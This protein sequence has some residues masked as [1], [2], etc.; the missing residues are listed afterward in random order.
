MAGK[1]LISF[2]SCGRAKLLWVLFFLTPFAKV[3]GEN[4]PT[5]PL[6][7][8]ESSRLYRQA[9]VTP[10]ARQ[11]GFSCAFFA[12]VPLVTMSSGI[13]IADGSAASE[14]FISSIYGLRRGD[15][16]FMRAYD[17]EIFFQIFSIPANGVKVYYRDAS[18][19]ELLVDAKSTVTQDLAV[20]L[21]KGMFV[22]LRI[23]GSLGVPH[24]VL[25][26]AYRKDL[27]YYHDPRTGSIVSIRVEELA[28]KILCV[29][30]VQ[31]EETNRYFSSYHLVSLP[32]PSRVTQNFL[33]IENLAKE[34]EINLTLLQ[35]TAISKKLEKVAGETGVSNSYPEIHFA[36]LK[37]TGKSVISEDLEVD[38]MK[39][40]FNLTKLAVSSYGLGT[41]DVLPVWLVDGVP[42]VAMGY[43]E[44]ENS[45]VIFTNGIHRTEMSCDD[46]L[47]KFKQSGCFLGYV[48]LAKE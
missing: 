46:A 3:C 33:K 25:L 41:R 19:G 14:K 34:Q 18:R 4:F 22:S 38:R 7:A 27:Y 6:T 42:L 43:S 10:G 12:N 36:I 23:M 40:V 29:S 26:L 17:R 24:N 20:A 9:R 21:D 13:N 28:S 11:I 47:K 45:K 2:I 32:A 5:E 1:F 16:D 35:L 44:S 39:G 30:K 37:K 15:F 48:K 31:D 8:E